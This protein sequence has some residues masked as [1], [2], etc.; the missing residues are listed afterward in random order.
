MELF[1]EHL[2]TNNFN[3]IEEWVQLVEG[4]EVVYPFNR[5]PFEEWLDDYISIIHSKS[6]RD[7]KDLLRLLLRPYTTKL[8]EYVQSGNTQTIAVT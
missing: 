7:V 5:I 1:N 8:D 4:R 2:Y 6:E 3:D